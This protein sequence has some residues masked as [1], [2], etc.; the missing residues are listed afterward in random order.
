ME[1]GVPL[2]DEAL[3]RSFG[4]SDALVAV[5][6]SLVYVFHDVLADGLAFTVAHL[7]GAPV[8]LDEL[9]DTSDRDRFEV[10]VCTA[11]PPSEAKEV[12]IADSLPVTDDLDSEQLS[13]MSAKQAA[14]EMVR[15]L[16]R[17]LT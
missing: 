14:F 6:K 16:L 11:F 9:F 5:R 1:Q 17:L 8:F 4:G 12:W 10:A 7:P 13:A 2:V 15:M 3:H